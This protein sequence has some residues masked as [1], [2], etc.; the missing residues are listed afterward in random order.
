MAT[1]VGAFIHTSLPSPFVS[2]TG[3]VLP[4]TLCGCAIDKDDCRFG[5]LQNCRCAAGHEINRYSRL[6][7]VGR[8][9][10]SW[11]RGVHTHPSALPVRIHLRIDAAYHSASLRGDAIDTEDYRVGWS[12][13]G[14]FLGFHDRPRTPSR[15]P[16]RPRVCQATP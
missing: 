5:I 15:C 14:E 7:M 4:L 6:Q 1:G 2:I 13:F 10:P 8:M 12:G 16:G 11:C 9:V 3:M